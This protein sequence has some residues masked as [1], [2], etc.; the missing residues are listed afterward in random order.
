MQFQVYSHNGMKI[1]RYSLSV[2]STD[3]KR[4]S[5]V[6]KPSLKVIHLKTHISSPANVHIL[7]YRGECTETETETRSVPSIKVKMMMCCLLVL[8]S[9][10][11]TPQ[12]IRQPRPRV[13]LKEGTYHTRLFRGT[14][15]NDMKWI[16]FAEPIK[17]QWD[18]EKQIKRYRKKNQCEVRLTDSVHDAFQNAHLFF[19]KKNQCAVGLTDSVHGALKTH[20]CKLTRACMQCGPRDRQTQCIILSKRTF[21]QLQTRALWI[22]LLFLYRIMNPCIHC[23]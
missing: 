6:S 16:N 7:E 12:W 17:V 18:D 10:T 4:A 5:K 9:V 20:I 15:T 2:G 22:I 3:T 1:K 13:Y 8:D 14:S 19:K 21:V 11:S 23:A